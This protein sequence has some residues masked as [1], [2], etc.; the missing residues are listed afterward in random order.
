MHARLAVF[1]AAA[2][3]M[4]STT[5]TAHAAAFDGP[6]FDPIHAP[7]KASTAD[8]DHARVTPPLPSPYTFPADFGSKTERRVTRL[9]EVLCTEDT[10]SDSMLKAIDEAGHRL[11]IRWGK[12]LG[13]D[14]EGVDVLAEARKAATGTADYTNA[15]RRELCDKSVASTYR[16]KVV[17]LTKKYGITPNTTDSKQIRRDWI[18]HLDA[19]KTAVGDYISDADWS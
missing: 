11:P 10:L 5:A 13:E 15:A 8:E 7:K 1:T 2:V 17:E 3:I 12:N 4:L 19:L 16:S 9:D 6:G 14:D 18:D